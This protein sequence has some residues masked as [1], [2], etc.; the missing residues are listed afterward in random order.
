MSRNVMNM[1]TIKDDKNKM[2]KEPLVITKQSPKQAKL[3]LSDIIFTTI[4]ESHILFSGTTRLSI[5]FGHRKIQNA[6]KQKADEHN[7]LNNGRCG[8]MVNLP[9]GCFSKLPLD[10]LAFGKN[11]VNKT[12]PGSPNKGYRCDNQDPPLIWID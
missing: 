4:N 2:P 3:G 10:Y 12:Q 8:A 9:V 11:A 6:V 5:C 1:S 7:P